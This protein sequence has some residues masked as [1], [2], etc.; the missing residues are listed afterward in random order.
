MDEYICNGKMIK[1]IRKCLG[2]SQSE[3]ASLLSVK[4]RQT[5]SKWERDQS[6]PNWNLDQSMALD[7]ALAEKGKRLS[8][9]DTRVN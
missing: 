5:I 2:M 8:D 9:F 6:L 1:N 7:K 4:N 3:F